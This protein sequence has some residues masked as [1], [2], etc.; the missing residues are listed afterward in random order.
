VIAQQVI[1]FDPALPLPG[2]PMED[3]LNR[4]GNRRVFGL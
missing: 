1:L 3:V 4:Q 2:Q